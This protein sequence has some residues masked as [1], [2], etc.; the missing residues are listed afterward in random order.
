[1]GSNQ[2]PHLRQA[3]DRAIGY[4]VT[5]LISVRTLDDGQ[6]AA[7]LCDVD[8]EIKLGGNAVSILALVKYTETTGDQQ[9]WN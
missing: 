2:Q 6:Q 4:L 1:M 8:N 3:I 5:N 9:H 7:F